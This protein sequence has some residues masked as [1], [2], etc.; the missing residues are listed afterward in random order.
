MRG[1]RLG[2][3]CPARAGG[4]RWLTV[5]GRGARPGPRS[6][7]RG[8]SRSSCCARSPTRARTR[9]SRCPG[10]SPGAELA[11][12]DAAFA[13]EL[14]YGT[15]RA[16]GTL[17]A[18]IAALR[19]PP[20]RRHRARRPRRCCA[21]APTSCCAPASRRTPRSRRPSI[22]LAQ[23]G[24][25][26]PAGFV[27]AVLRRVVERDWDGWIDAARRRAQGASA[28]WRC[29]PRTRNGSSGPSPQRLGEAGDDL[30]E[31][32]ARAGG[33]RR[34][35][36]SRIWSRG[37]VGRPRP[38]CSPPSA[39]P[40]ADPGPVFAVRGP[41]GRR[42]P[43]R[44]RRDPGAPRRGAGRGQ[45]AVRA[46]P[47][48]AAA[49][50]RPRRALARPVRRP[51]RQGGAAGRARGRARRACSTPTSCS[52]HRADLV[53]SV[54]RARGTSQVRV[55]DA[56]DYPATGRRLRPGAASTPRAPGWARCAAGPRPAGGA[57]E[58][59]WSSWSRCSASC[60]RPRCASP[61]RAAL[62]AYVTCSP[63]L[64]ETDATMVAGPRVWS[65]PAPA[66]P[67]VDRAR[68]RARRCSCGRTGTAPTRCSAR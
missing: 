55:G 59:T 41:D 49:G 29:A 27:N 47:G 3:R 30:A 26:G 68:R 42:R 35:P 23:S 14:G 58:S 34:P 62:V 17:D 67:G 20:G 13:T 18:V 66:F 39:T 44:H 11:G 43:G 45:P 8:W 10:C 64:A 40:A 22:W 63:H 32:A 54:D 53:R 31:T 36:A 65:T 16:Q 28:R 2:A 7:R 5:A 15:L 52:P 21:S 56:R 33:R 19:R 12:R 38:S 4:V 24:T 1:R 57:A 25:A 48:S 37:R 46:R 51:G 60:S 9:T 61:A 6:T 50:R